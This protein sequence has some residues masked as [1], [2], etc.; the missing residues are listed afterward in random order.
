M[1]NEMNKHMNHLSMG[2]L[3]NVEMREHRLKKAPTRTELL[4]ME[5]REHKLG[6]R[7]TMRQAM[8]AE[9]VEHSNAEGKLVIRPSKAQEA[10]AT[11]IYKRGK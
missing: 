9:Y 5:Q 1:L 4:K 2:T 8:E 6:N 11:A 7:P 3:M 10:K